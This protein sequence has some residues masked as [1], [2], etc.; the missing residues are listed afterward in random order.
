MITVTGIDVYFTLTEECSLRVRDITKTDVLL[1]SLVDLLVDFF[2]NNI[3]V[4]QVY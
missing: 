4:V 1:V 3:A 2:G